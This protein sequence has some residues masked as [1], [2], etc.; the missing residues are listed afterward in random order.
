MSATISPLCTEPVR[1]S[2]FS[3][4]QIIYAPVIPDVEWD[5]KMTDYLKLLLLGSTV[6]LP[7]TA[8]FA[9]DTND[10]ENLEELVVTA[11]RRPQN[12]SDIGASISVLNK[13]AL[14]EGQFAFVI[15]ALQTLPGV[16]INQNGSIGGL[17]TV[18]IRGA[19]TDQTVVLIDG[20]QVNDASAPGGGFDFSTLDPSTIERIEVLKGPQAVLYGSDAIGGVVNIITKSGASGFGGSAF[21]EFGAYDTVRAGTSF[22]GGSGVLSFNVAGSYINSDGISR[23]DEGTEADGYESYTLRGRVTAEITDALEVELFGSYS[24]SEAENDA[25]VFQPDFTFGLADTADLSVSEEYLIGGRLRLEAFDGKLD[26]TVSIEYSGIDR[27]SISETGSFPAEGKRFNLDY[28]GVFAFDDHWSLSAGAQHENVT[29]GVDGATDSFSINSLFGLLSY[30]QNG[31]NLSGGLR[32]DDHEQY[33]TITSTQFQASYNIDETGTRVFANYGEGFK[34]PSVFQLTFICGFCGLTAPNADLSPERSDAFE[35]GIEQKF[36]GDALK[37]GVTYF[38]QTIEDLI[39]FSFTAGFDNIKNAKLDGVEISLDATLSD[40]VS[41][42]A[43]YSI[44]NAED[45]DTGARLVRRPKNQFYANLKWA[46]S[47]AFTTNIAVTHNGNEVDS[48]G[49]INPSWTRVDLRASYKIDDRYELYGRIDNLF[50]NQYQQI[51]G[52]GTPGISSFFGV[53]STF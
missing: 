33:G 12:L 39:D 18:S 1:F 53:R 50:D 4:Q 6:L 52:F 14:N 31:F 26:N 13:N 38:D 42:A 46:M 20:V 23:F 19:A 35:F 27:E 29:S 16:S 2:T 34:A 25:F 7:A 36:L 22:S 40:A 11:S 41:F 28:L 17:A 51:V 24:D 45:T 43:N 49:S 15:D 30:S 21:A 10:D 9:Q 3:L 32:T 37:I 44:T 48:P 5:I 8:S 47:D